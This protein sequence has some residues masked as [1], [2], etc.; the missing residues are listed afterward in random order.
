MNK[1]VILTKKQ[2]DFLLHVY[3]MED[4]SYTS[5]ITRE[6]IKNIIMSSRYDGAIYSYKLNKLRE[7][8]I[9]SNP[10][11]EFISSGSMVNIKYPGKV[12]PELNSTYSKYDIEYDEN[13]LKDN[14]PF[15]V[16]ALLIINPEATRLLNQRLTAVIE[17]KLVTTPVNKGF[18]I[19]VEGLRLLP[20]PVQTGDI[21]VFNGDDT[22]SNLTKGKLYTVMSQYKESTIDIGSESGLFVLRNDEGYETLC[23]LYHPCSQINNNRWYIYSRAKKK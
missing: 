9:Q 14:V 13:L 10:L 20:S 23:S 15:R 16:K 21:V 17:Y 4:T 18:V 3:C 1:T 12:Y 5:I 22:G 8:I 7:H 6:E 19:D 11:F 2:E